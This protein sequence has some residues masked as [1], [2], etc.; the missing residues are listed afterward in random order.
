MN[1]EALN[2]LLKK[3]DE[4]SFAQIFEALYQPLVSY[5]MQYV[6]KA[7][8]AEDIAQNTFIKLW[9]KKDRLHLNTSVKSYIYSAA[10][11]QFIDS[12]RKQKKQQ[13]YLDQLKNET[14]VNLMEDP[15]DLLERKLQLIT[16]AVDSLPERCRIIF[17]MH[18]KQGYSHKE[19]SKQLEISTKTI[20]AQLRIAY[21][22][23]REELKNRPDLYLT[24]IF[25]KN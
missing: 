21:T 22:R 9:E 8:D 2:D 25:R 23:L 1:N 19:I 24:L 12:Y 11:N 3:G 15:D 14:L 17:I 20:E 4:H 18:K 7:A 16:K 6:D 5:L 13:T 10:Y